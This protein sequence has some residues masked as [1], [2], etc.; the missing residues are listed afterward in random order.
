VTS[1]GIVPDRSARVKNRRTGGVA[2]R[3]Q[4][5]VDDLAVLVNSR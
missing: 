5:D 3:G 4:H 2:P 1:A